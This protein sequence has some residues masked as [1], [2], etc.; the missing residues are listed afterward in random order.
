MAR[1]KIKKRSA[2]EPGETQG[3]EDAEST[4]YEKSEK[5]DRSLHKA[6]GKMGKKLGVKMSKQALAED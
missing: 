5:E 6:V 4:A 1:P 3:H 2:P